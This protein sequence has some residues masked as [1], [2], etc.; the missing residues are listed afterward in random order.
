MDGNSKPHLT[1]HEAIVLRMIADGF[2]LKE[3]AAHVGNSEKTINA[4]RYNISKKFCAHGVAQLTRLAIRNGLIACLA[5]P[6]GYDIEALRIS[7]LALSAALTVLRSVPAAEAREDG[8]VRL[9]WPCAAITFGGSGI[10]ET[11]GGSQ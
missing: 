4:H 8:G 10:Q 5:E 9:T 7:N 6:D 11:N 2:T 3:I 1:P